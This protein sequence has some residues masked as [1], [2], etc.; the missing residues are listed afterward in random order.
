MGRREGCVA[1]QPLFVRSSTGGKWVD[2]AHQ[3]PVAHS[4]QFA[5]TI[6]AFA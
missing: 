2:Y 6:P 3:V 1:A 4:V 5:S